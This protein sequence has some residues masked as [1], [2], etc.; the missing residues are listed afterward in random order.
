MS[1]FRATYPWAGRGTRSRH[2]PEQERRAL[3]VWRSRHSLVGRL[4]GLWAGGREDAAIRLA[5][6][7]ERWY[8][9][10]TPAGGRWPYQWLIADVAHWPR[11]QE[12]RPGARVRVLEKRWARR[13]CHICQGTG[14]VIAFVDLDGVRRLPRLGYWDPAEVYEDCPQCEG[15]GYLKELVDT[16]RAALERAGYEVR[17]WQART[18]EWIAEAR[19]QSGQVMAVGGKSEEA[20]LRY[21]AGE[22]GLFVEEALMGKDAQG[23]GQ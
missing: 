21:L 1:L 18:G 5:S 11:I 16:P 22:L 14:S 9:N 13:R 7:T 15:T 19:L 2:N 3:E 10:R 23:N 8:G 20:A 4:V 17:T 6:H 12:P